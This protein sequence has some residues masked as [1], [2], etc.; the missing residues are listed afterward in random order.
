MGQSAGDS[1]LNWARDAFLAE[2]AW[3]G[4]W[5]EG[6]DER[7]AP[8]RLALLSNCRRVVRVGAFGAESLCE[9]PIRL[10]AQRMWMTSAC[11]PV[12][13][14]LHDDGEA[15]WTFSPV[16]APEREKADTVRAVRSAIR[17][18][19]GAN[20]AMLPDRPWL[21]RWLEDA[22]YT[23]MVTVLKFPFTRKRLL[24]AWLANA[25]AELSRT[26][27][28]KSY[29]VANLRT[30]S[31]S[32]YVQFK[33]DSSGAWMYGEASAP[34]V[35]TADPRWTAGLD[36]DVAEVLGWVHEDRFYNAFGVFACPDARQLAM[37][38]E[39][40]IDTLI[41]RAYDDGPGDFEGEYVEYE[42]G[43]SVTWTCAFEP[44]SQPHDLCPE[45]WYALFGLSAEQFDADHDGREGRAVEHPS[46]RSAN[47]AAPEPDGSWGPEPSAGNV[48]PNPGPYPQ[49]R[50]LPPDDPLFK[51]GATE[52][53]SAIPHRRAAPPTQP[54]SET[55]PKG[56]APPPME[57]PDQ[58]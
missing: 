22:E 1:W 47:E 12:L 36:T 44:S 34:S 25:L 42:L 52:F 49:S 8:L 40:A 5:A 56:D 10:G 54:D 33:P 23:A 24:V 21:G 30:K 2:G 37:L 43:A 39:L 26:R 14:Q 17:T 32:A 9:R 29:V 27:D 55:E 45:A 53:F 7:G 16:E 15:P 20:L 46:D 50:P 41:A 48:K 31:R 13:L 57:A 58:G 18:F 4:A 19:Q 35:H 11:S 51:S 3:S 6:R 38:A 28:E